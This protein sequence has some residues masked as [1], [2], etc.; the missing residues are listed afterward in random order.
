MQKT[1]KRE[2]YQKKTSNHQASKQAMKLWVCSI[3]L[4][5]G[6]GFDG[7]FLSLPTQTVSAIPFL[8]SPVLDVL[9]SFILILK[10]IIRQL[11]KSAS[12]FLPQPKNV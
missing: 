6:K 5:E 12:F 1:G 7:H 3:N 11:I 9:G 2:Y 8:P 4:Q 10:K